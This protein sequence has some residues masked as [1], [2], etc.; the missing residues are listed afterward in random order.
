MKTVRLYPENIRH[1][2]LILVN[3]DWPLSNEPKH[4]FLSPV[5]YGDNAV[6]MDRQAAKM[7]AKVLS[8]LDGGDEITAVCGFRTENEQRR[9]YDASLKENGMHFTRR[10]VAFPG[11]SEHQTGLAVDLARNSQPVDFIRPHFPYSG[12]CQRFRRKAANYGFVERYPKGRERITKIAHEPWHFRFVGYPHSRIMADAQ[13]TLEEYTDYLRGFEF[14]KERLKFS[15][16]GIRWEIG[17]IRPGSCTEIK[18]PPHTAY[19]LSG[20]NVDGIVATLWEL[21]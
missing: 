11:C 21:R 4:D 12:V 13:F 6:L 20:N 9:I 15:Y 18:V 10:Y 1:G 7:L 3:S 2:N 17:F 16:S 5:E 14:E 8:A 19:Q